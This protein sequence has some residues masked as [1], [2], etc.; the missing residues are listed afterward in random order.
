MKKIKVELNLYDITYLLSE[1]DSAYELGYFYNSSVFY[2]FSIIDLH[3]KMNKKLQNL[4]DRNRENRTFKLSL[5]L[6]EFHALYK[7]LC[8]SNSSKES[9]EMQMLLND[10]HQIHINLPEYQ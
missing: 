1:I 8:S 4:I 5:R 9:N 3:K 2:V 6:N 10:L 7:Y